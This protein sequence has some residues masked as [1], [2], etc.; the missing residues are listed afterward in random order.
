M[1]S[2]A[3]DTKRQLLP[4]ARVELATDPSPCMHVNH[5]YLKHHCPCSKGHSRG[6]D[7]GA[8]QEL[9][10]ELG[11]TE[12]ES[13]GDASGGRVANVSRSK[14]RSADT[15]GYRADFGGSMETETLLRKKGG[16][17]S[18]SSHGKPPTVWEV[19]STMQSASL[20]SAV[21]L[22]GMGSGVIETFLFIRYLTHATIETCVHG[23]YQVAYIYIFCFSSLSLA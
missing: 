22:S 12:T 8:T 18:Q 16:Y 5:K 17:Q 10:L 14:K 2:G 15:K 11:E 6:N 3:P 21:V 19:I 13:D 1:Y 4:A 20:F 23:I 9:V 7:Y